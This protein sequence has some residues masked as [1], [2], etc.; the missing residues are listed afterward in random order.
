MVLNFQL[1]FILNFN[2]SI[3]LLINVVCNY[4]LINF[5]LFKWWLNI[6]KSKK[7]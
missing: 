1:F 5:S 2:L 6:F 3:T 7:Y 4:I